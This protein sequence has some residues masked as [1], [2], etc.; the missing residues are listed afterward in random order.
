MT[1]RNITFTK[2]FLTLGCLALSRIA[3]AVSPVPD[4]VYPGRNTAEGQ[5]ALLSLTTGTYNAAVS[6][7]IKNLQNC[8]PA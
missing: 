3:H 6:R 8:R 4:G 5:T 1:N 2:I 7:I